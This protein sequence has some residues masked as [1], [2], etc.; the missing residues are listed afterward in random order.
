[1]SYQNFNDIFVK[2]TPKMDPQI[3]FN[4]LDASW[5]YLLRRTKKREGAEGGP[6]T[7]GAVPN[8]VFRLKDYVFC[9]TAERAEGQVLHPETRRYEERKSD[10]LDNLSTK[11]DSMDHNCDSDDDDEDEDVEND[12]D[13][14]KQSLKPVVDRQEEPKKQDE[15]PEL[16]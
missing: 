12:F 15:A 6:H 10:S 5:D 14:A 7:S 1:M 3:F 2:I 13:D 11:S 8:G 16:I 4:A 9:R